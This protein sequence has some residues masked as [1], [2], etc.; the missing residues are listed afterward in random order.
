MKTRSFFSTITR[1][2]TALMLVTCAAAPSMGLAQS[3]ADLTDVA[4]TFDYATERDL[5]L[6]IEAFDSEGVPAD[7]RVVEVLEPLDDEGIA[8]RVID[9]A[10]TDADG[11]LETRVRVPAHVQQVVVRVAVL[12]IDNDHTVAVAAS[13]VVQHVFQ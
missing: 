5:W 10:V 1:F 7:N 12:G 2:A 4:D 13:D 9:K 11:W 3:L 8:F 6:E